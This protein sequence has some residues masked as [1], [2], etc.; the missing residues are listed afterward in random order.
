MLPCG[1]MEGDETDAWTT[2]GLVASGVVD[3][4]G[5]SENGQQSSQTKKPSA[6]I[7]LPPHAHEKERA[8]FAPAVADAGEESAP[9][10]FMRPPAVREQAR[11]AACDSF[12]DDHARSGQAN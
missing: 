10:E 11:V 12:R 9:G 8:R 6:Q 4:L 7:N 1:S 5:S 3:A 2:L